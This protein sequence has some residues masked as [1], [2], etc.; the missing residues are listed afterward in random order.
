[1]QCAVRRRAGRRVCE[2]EPRPIAALEC[3]GRIGQRASGQRRLSAFVQRRPERTRRSRRGALVCD[4]SGCVFQLVPHT[5]SRISSMSHKQGHVYFRMV[6]CISA[7]S[8]SKSSVRPVDPFRACRCYACW[9][10]HGKQRR[11]DVHAE[12]SG[13]IRLHVPHPGLEPGKGHGNVQRP[14]NVRP[15]RHLD[16]IGNHVE[17]RSEMDSQELTRKPRVTCRRVRIA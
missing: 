3:R 13:H 9:N 15:H 5:R 11:H 1:V 14:V 7:W 17:Q 12:R 4:D 2:Q 16:W 10:L 6:T 8:R